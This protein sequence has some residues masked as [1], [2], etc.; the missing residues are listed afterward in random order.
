MSTY[1]SIAD[2]IQEIHYWLRLSLLLHE[3]I[4]KALL[5]ILFNTSNDPSYKGLPC[6]PADLFQELSSATNS[7]IIKTLTKKGVIR[8]PQMIILFPPGDNKTHIEKMDSTL[9]VVLIR[10]FTTLPAP[11][12]GWDEKTPPLID[13]T[14]AAFCI[15]AREWRNFLIHTEPRKIDEL[16]FHSKWQQ[17]EAIVTGLRYAYDTNYLM[18]ISLDPKHQLVLKGLFMFLGNLHQVQLEQ[19]RELKEQAMYNQEISRRLSI[20]SDELDR[21]RINKTSSTIVIRKNSGRLL[22][23]C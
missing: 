23:P 3:P 1:K 16:V 7:T 6:D 17:G 21:L 9:I 14:I 4:Q 22:L 10:N 15:R 18:T 20:I 12:C 13:I 2:T 5:G 19:Q 11:T 8:Q